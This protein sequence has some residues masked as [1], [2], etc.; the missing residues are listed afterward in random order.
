MSH[1]PH[2]LITYKPKGNGGGGRGRGGEGVSHRPHCLI[3]YKPKGNGGCPTVHTTL[4]LI[5]LRGTGR[6][7]GGVPPSTLP[8]HL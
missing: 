5:N 1:R 3:T 4:S 6:G 8:Y 7:G 2:C